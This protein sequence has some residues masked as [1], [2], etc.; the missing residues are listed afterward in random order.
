MLI[1]PLGPGYAVWD[2]AATVRFR[3]PGRT[4]LYA[5]FEIPPA[6]LDSIRSELGK[7]AKMDRVCQVDLKSADGT[8]HAS[9]EKTIHV[10]RREIETGNRSGP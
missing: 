4:T 7:A 1:H 3:R 8:V 10:S 9:V 5:R 6:E 2:K